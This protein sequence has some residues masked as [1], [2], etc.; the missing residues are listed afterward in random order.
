MSAG[1]LHGLLTTRRGPFPAEAGL[2][3]VV[4]R[5]AGGHGSA[6]HRALDPIPAA[7]AMVSELPT[8]VTRGFDVFDPVVITVGAFHAGTQNDVIPDAAELEATIR[9]FSAAAHDRVKDGVVRLCRGIAQAHGLSVE[10]DYA[11]TFPVTVNDDS[12]ADVL[13]ETITEVCGEDRFVRA[14]NPLIGSEDFSP[15]LT[16]VPGAF[17][18]TGPVL[19]DADPRAMPDNHSPQA[20]FD[21][22]VLADGAAGYA[23]LAVRRLA[24]AKAQRPSRVGGS[25]S[26]IGPS[27]AG[28]G[29]A[30]HTGEAGPQSGRRGESGGPRDGL[31]RQVGALQELSRSVQPCPQQPLPRGGADFR[32]EATQQ[33][34]LAEVG[35]RGEIGEIQLTAEVLQRPRTGLGQCGAAGVG[36][37]GRDELGLSTVAVRSDDVP[38]GE[39]GRRVGAVVA[40]DQVQREIQAAGQPGGGEHV[41]VVHVEH[42]VDDGR[43]SELL[44]EQARR[45]PVGG[46]LPPVEQAGMAQREGPHT[47]R[48]H[49]GPSGRGSSQRDGDVLVRRGVEGPEKAWNHDRVGV[50]EGIEVVVEGKREPVGG[51]D[52]PAAR[53][54][55]RELVERRRPVL[56]R[57][58]AEDLYGAAEVEGDQTRQRQGHHTVRHRPIV[59][60]EW[61]EIN[62]QRRTAI[63][64]TPARPRDDCWA[65]TAVL[66]RSAP[67]L[68]EH[69]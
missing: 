42:V 46:G 29:R 43:V 49:P 14:K 56:G 22:A 60:D 7:G 21:D 58:V 6:P 65:R 28:R 68:K 52:F 1:L 45:D 27:V 30:Q 38:P 64:W 47:D 3:P 5:G 10:I 24:T 19:A 33:R 48:H 57:P 20:V 51:R 37:G 66:D 53:S 41:T 36:H 59:A 69:Q 9:S 54:A 13:A 67:A 16:E 11:Q 26:A 12:E 31:D 15:V 2:L 25:R 4:V 17:A 62:E 23:G 50:G 55:D 18:A 8:M 39:L 61:R 63:S 35:V 40:A 32:A 34:A 44:G